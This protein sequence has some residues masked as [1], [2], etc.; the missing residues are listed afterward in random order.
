MEIERTVGQ[1]R[2]FYVLLADWTWWAWTVTAIL[3]L[4]GLL[5]EP[6]GFL[7]AMLLTVVQGI[8]M[9]IREK[10]Y[11]GFCSATSP[12]LLPAA[13]DLFCSSYA[14]AVLGADSRDFCSGDLW[15]L[16]DGADALAFAVEPGRNA[17]S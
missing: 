4:I 3:L 5:E 17:F 10:P 16:S 13:G 12:G 9:L 7:A 6:I 15:L 11:F 14:L 1:G 2:G 8:V